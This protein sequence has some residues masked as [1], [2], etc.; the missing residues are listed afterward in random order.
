MIKIRKAAERGQAHHGWLDSYHSFSFAQYHDPEHMG[1]GALRVINEDYVQPGKGFGTHPHQNME[2]L[3]YVLEGAIEH[4]DSMGNGSVIRPGEVQ[5]MSAG[6]GVTHSEFN[7]SPDEMVH[8][9]QIWVIP[10]EQGGEP[11]Y[12]Q[13]PIPSNHSQA[14]TLIASPNAE[15]GSLHIKQDARIY[16]GI[17]EAGQ[18]LEHRVEAQ[19]QGW[20]QLARGELSLSAQGLDSQT[21]QAGDGI[22]LQDQG[23]LTL[24]AQQPS[25]FL[26]FDLPR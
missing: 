6:R 17:L 23:S 1:F 19:R 15:Q 8:F 7:H 21:L 5:L 20:L 16:R 3:T 22:A 26:L 12:Q 2:I 14:L 18:T 25:E 9:L 24:N 11:G 10:N 4:K 13:Q